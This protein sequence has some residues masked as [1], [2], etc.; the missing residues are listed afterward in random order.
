VDKQCRSVAKSTTHLVM[1]SGAPITRRAG[2]VSKHNR[3][4][5]ITGENLKA[6]VCIFWA[7]TRKISAIA[8]GATP[9]GSTDRAPD[10]NGYHWRK[11]TG[12]ID[13]LFIDSNLRHH[14]DKK[15][16][17]LLPS[18]VIHELFEEQQECFAHFNS[19]T[20]LAIRS[21]KILR[22]SHRDKAWMPWS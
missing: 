10:D 6:T 17:W 4:K 1:D 9:I 16:N 22:L 13:Y 8:S 2:R 12:V 21:Q 3:A 20:R 15:Q 5:T 14:V 7:Y 18:G 19:Q 11:V